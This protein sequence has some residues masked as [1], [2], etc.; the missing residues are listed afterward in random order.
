MMPMKTSPPISSES[1]AVIVDGGVYQIQNMIYSSAESKITMERLYDLG[2]YDGLE[3]KVVR[4]LFFGKVVIIQF[5][6]TL[7]ALNES[8]MACLVL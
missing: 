1:S 6:Q 2:L 4:Q 7:L 8:E 3:F 5:E